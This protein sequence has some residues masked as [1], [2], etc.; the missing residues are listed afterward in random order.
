MLQL[1]AEPQTHGAGRGS[2]RADGED[3]PFSPL[4][5]GAAADYTAI[6]AAVC[7]CAILLRLAWGADPGLTR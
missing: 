3:E 7:G 2:A 5:S 4:E 6:C 1:V